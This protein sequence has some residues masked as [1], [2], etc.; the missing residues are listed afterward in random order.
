MLIRWRRGWRRV[1]TAGAAVLVLAGCAGGSGQAT[2]GR[3]PSPSAADEVGFGHVHG[4]GV[5][6]GDGDLYAAT[7]YGLW[8]I[9]TRGQGAMVRVADR[10]QDTMGFTVAGPD[11]FLGS[12]HPDP[13]ED[14]PPLLGLVES[15]DRGQTWAP[16]SLLGQVDFHAL[17]AKHGHVYGY[18]STS[19]TV[20][21][22][23]DGRAWARRARLPLRDLTV[24]PDNPDTVLAAA[25]RGLLRSTDQGR[26]FTAV[27]GAP[28]LVVLDWADGHLLGV[29]AD[30]AVWASGDGGATW[31]RRG[32]LG[33]PHALA[34]TGD[35]TVYAADDTGVHASTDAGRTFTSVVT[36]PPTSEDQ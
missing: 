7:H 19:G 14:L 3:S 30:G 29:A 1:A 23:G 24:H 8:R 31:D 27:P 4:L 9:P 26:T 32:S 25:P 13:R 28:Q 36:Y 21:V 10:Y 12:G 11:R 17:E 2:A 15:R 5:N 16:V 33:E 22:S 6:P 18:D 34:V 35:G 20:L